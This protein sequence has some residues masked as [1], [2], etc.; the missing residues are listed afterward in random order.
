MTPR[1]NPAGAPG[2][3]LTDTTALIESRHRLQRR[4]R[5]IRLASLIGAVVV[6]LVVVWAIWFSGIFVARSFDVT[7]ASQVSPDAVAEATQIGL[8]TPLARVDVSAA[9][10]RVRQLPPVASVDI[11]RGLNGVIHVQITERVAVYA[12][13]TAGRFT[14][15][16]AEGV[17]Y[18]EQDSAPAGLVLVN[19]PAGATEDSARLMADAATIIA[20]LPTVV[21]DQMATMDASTPDTFTIRLNNGADVFWGSAEQSTQ[22]ATVMEGLIKIAANHYDVSSPGHPATR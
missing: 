2:S 13:P 17:G 8:G 9:E 14:L 7:G 15:V 16:D 21:R 20:A 22:K 18:L 10:D 3:T 19:L 1:H 11:N 12:A 4:R 5:A 6:I